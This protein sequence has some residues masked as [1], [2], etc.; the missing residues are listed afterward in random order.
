MVIEKILNGELIQ[1]QETEQ[2]KLQAREGFLKGGNKKFIE[3][4]KDE[5]K[6]APIKVKT[7]IVNKQKNLALLTDKVVN[8]LRQ[9]I[10]TPAIGQDPEMIKLLAY[11]G[12]KYIFL[13][14][15]SGSEKIRMQIYKRSET[16]EDLLRAYSYFIC[17]YG[18]LWAD[19]CRFS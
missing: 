12:L 19:L 3:I 7:N 4:L 5:L 11:A 10:A 6:D 16:N 14:M 13:G 8:V 1:P 18:V 9:F 2:F 17:L 15:Q